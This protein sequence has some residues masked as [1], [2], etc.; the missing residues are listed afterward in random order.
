MH[1]VSLRVRACVCV[2][3]IGVSTAAGVCDRTSHRMS[4]PLLYVP[5]AH[6]QPATR[7]TVPAAFLPAV[8]FSYTV[9]KCKINLRKTFVCINYIEKPFFISEL[10]MIHLL[11]SFSYTTSVK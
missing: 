1:E 7:S 2:Q 5:A 6:S 8:P 10:C 4:S 9:R 3:C 11:V